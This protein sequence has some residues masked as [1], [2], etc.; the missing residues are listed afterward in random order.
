MQQ[1]Q[2]LVTSALPY[3]NA[4][5]HLGHMVE[6]LQT[7]IWVGFQ[8]LRGHNVRFFCADDTHG[9]ATMLRAQEE[10]RAPE[11]LLD[12]MKAAHLADLVDFGVHH[13]HYS[14]THSAANE[15]IVGEIWAALRADGRVDER[16]VTQL[17]D[18]EAG[19]FLADRF[20]IGGCPKCK[21][22]GQYGD[23]CEVCGATYEPGDLIGPKSS[24]TGA[25]PEERSHVHL[26]VKLEGFHEFL[27]EWTQ[28]PGKVPV[29]T[30]NWLKGTFLAETLRDWDISRPAPYFGFEIPDAPGQ[31]FYV[32]LDAPIGYIS[33]TK[34]W[35][36]ANG[37]QLDNWW[38][39]PDSEIHHF[40]GK[41]IAYFHTLFWP[42]MLKTAGFQL[43]TSVHVHGFLTVNGEKMSKRKGTFVLARTYLEHLNPEYLRYYYASKL[44]AKVDDLDLNLDEF[45]QKV[46]SD[47]VGKV[48]NL[49]SRTARFVKGK[50]LPETYPAA[51]DEGLFAAAAAVGEEIAAAYEA[52]DSGKATRL[53]MALAD[54]ANE[55]VES[56]EPWTL[57]K[58]AEKAEELLEVCAVALNL[59]RQIT[60]YLGP[61]LPRFAAESAKL[62]G[63]EGETRW[64]DA[65]TPVVGQTVGT[66]KHL[67]ER[68]DPEK[69]TAM[70]EA[71]REL[72]AA[73]AAKEGATGSAFA[74]A[75]ALAG[76]PLEAECTIDDFTKVDLRIAEIVEAKAVPKANKLLELTLSLGGD[77]RRTVFA[78]IKKAYE[79]EDL[80]GR[81]TVMVANLAPRKMK[82][83]L[84]EGMVLAAGPGDSELF[85]LSPDSGAKPGQRVR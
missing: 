29:E 13:D 26:F 73:N 85:I 78:G 81:L 70:V 37:D 28:T 43:P 83:G 61:V 27:D 62:L 7:D 68:V 65:A 71:S 8:R 16:E 21:S 15:A 57:K 18:P 44:S 5:I 23:N 56:K 75:E 72:V 3:V 67:L 14:S 10:G 38:R 53:I 12:E 45:V 77:E 51:R 34:E 36:D 63:V 41:D 60:V 35:C 17:F 46:N 1:R 22:E 64:S 42:A 40:I 32:W 58:D 55:F 19:I 25:V 84:S 49:A 24:I 59:F 9:T 76:E 79:P 80:V 47:L 66:F 54:R 50:T 31:Y 6:H 2:I 4:G 82:F 33:T 48:V 74:G 69:V 20:V 39:N 30:A 52:R 11:A